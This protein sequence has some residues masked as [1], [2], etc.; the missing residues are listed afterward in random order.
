[1]TEVKV[2]NSKGKLLTTAELEKMKENNLLVPKENDEPTI[3]YVI[4]SLIEGEVIIIQK[5]RK[6]NKNNNQ[7]NKKKRI[8]TTEQTSLFTGKKITHI[9][10]NT[11]IVS[12]AT[13][14]K[15]GIGEIT[16]IPKEHNTKKTTTKRKKIDDSDISLFNRITIQNWRVWAGTQPTLNELFSKAEKESVGE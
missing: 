2:G 3:N 12:Q 6:K 9:T 7:N 8:L 5:K 1:M 14:S 4:P 15:E 11:E 16:K 13:L 10:T